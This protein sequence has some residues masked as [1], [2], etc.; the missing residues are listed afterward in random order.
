M[1]RS[2]SRSRVNIVSS[3]RE[4]SD[5]GENLIGRLVPDVWFWF[6]VSCVEE[7]LDR[8]FKL[9]DAAVTS[10]SDLLVG[11]LGEESFDLADP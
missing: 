2:L 11:E 9:S 5:A 8:S 7:V 1:V 3:A 6:L 10:S 4:A